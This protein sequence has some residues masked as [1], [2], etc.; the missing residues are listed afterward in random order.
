MC[1]FDDDGIALAPEFSELF[2][3]LAED[4][5][6]LNAILKAAKLEVKFSRAPGREA[7]DH[8]LF[9]AGGGHELF[10]AKVSEMFGDSDLGKIQDILEIAD[11]ERGLGEEVQDAQPGFVAEAFVDLD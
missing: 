10:A 3:V 6:R 8:P 11:T 2:E 1:G 4:G 9:V 7:V 5:M